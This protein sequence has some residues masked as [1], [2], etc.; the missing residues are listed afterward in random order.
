[1]CILSIVVLGWSN[2][3]FNP[4]LYQCLCSVLLAVPKSQ[5]LVIYCVIRHREGDFLWMSTGDQ[6]MP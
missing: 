5:K 4:V 3:L 2:G 1:M 6:F